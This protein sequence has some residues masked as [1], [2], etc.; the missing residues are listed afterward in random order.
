MATTNY[1]LPT[2]TGNM[3]ADVVRDMNALAEATDG[4]I[5]TA[6]DGVDLSAVEDEI[7]EVSG[8]LATHLADGAAHGIG[9]KTTLL[10]TNKTSI[11][12]ALNELFT[13]ANNG[14]SDIASVIGSPATSA[15]TFAQLKTH[16]QNSKDELA[17]NLSDKGQTS[18]SSES[19]GSL[20]SKVANINTGKRWASGT[21]TSNASPQKVFRSVSNGTYGLPTVTVT[22]LPFK[23]SLIYL[24][25]NNGSTVFT[26]VYSEYEND[27][28]PKTIKLSQ[29][30][31]S[32][33][34]LNSLHLKGDVSPASVINGSFVLGVDTGV[35][36]SQFT[37]IAIE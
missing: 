28:Y 30:N 2:I 35:T 29:F 1:N 3:N 33:A 20:V 27:M 31:K 19:L 26:S 17:L 18:I 8:N 13:N 34:T 22:G 14:K 21:V 23:P 11:V 9:D 15:N 7:A 4:A 10:T 25:H 6:I 36:V 24:F 37:W 5:K 16:I 12:S 32:A